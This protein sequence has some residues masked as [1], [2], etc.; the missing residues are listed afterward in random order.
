MPEEIEIPAQ[1][2]C[3]KI[4]RAAR[5]LTRFYDSCM[6][7]SGLRSTQFTILGYL[8]HRGEMPVGQLAQLVAMDRATMSHNLQPLERDGL[9]SIEVN[10]KD[11]R[12][13]IVK[14]TKAGLNA[15]AKARPGWDLAQAEFERLFGSPTPLSIRKMMDHV[16]SS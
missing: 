4:R 9:V 7:S 16:L 8:K 3:S 13:R 2:N 15:V 5:H 14:I 1:C 6:L 12:S 10:P 11:R